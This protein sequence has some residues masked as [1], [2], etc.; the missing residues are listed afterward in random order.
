MNAPR[1]GWTTGT[2]LA[3]ASSRNIA[4]R[5][6]VGGRH[7][8]HVELAQ[9]RQLAVA[10]DLASIRELVLQTRAAASIRATLVEIRRAARRAM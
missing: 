10:I 2:P 7:R 6:V 9:E 4:L 3:I 8:Q 5:L 1:R